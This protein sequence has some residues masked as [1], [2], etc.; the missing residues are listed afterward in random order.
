[1]AVL[2]RAKKYP[3]QLSQPRERARFLCGL[4]SPGFTRSRIS[5]D[6]SFGICESVPYHLVLEA[7]T[8]L[9]K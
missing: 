7:M 4:S 2:N 8:K 1:M 9:K 5:R 6:A 3:D